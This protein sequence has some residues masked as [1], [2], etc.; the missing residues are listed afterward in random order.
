MRKVS[1]VLAGALLGATAMSL[2]H[3]PQVIS[4]AWS[5]GNADTY[6][7]LNLFGDV[8]E[9]VRAD[10]VEKPDDKQLVENAIQG[11]LSGLDPHSSYMDEKRYRDRKVDIRG[12]FGGLGIEVTMEN[13]LVKVMSPIDDT[14]AARAGILANDIITH[15]D[16]E[17][18][19]GLTLPQAVEKMRGA[20]NTPITLRILR[21]DSEPKD[22]KLVRDVIRIRIVKSRAEEDLGYVRIAQFTEQ[23]EDEMLKAIE[24]IKKKIPDDKL[25][26]WV[27]DLRNNPGGLLDQSIRVVD[28]FLDRGEVVS[29]RGRRP[30][31]IDRYSARPGDVTGGKPIIVLVNGGSASASEIVSGALQDHKRATIL[32]TRTFGKGSVQTILELG[33]NGQ[34][35]ALSLTTARYYTPC[36]RSIQATGITPDIVLEP[37][38]PDELKGKD[39]MQ[40]EAGLRGHLRGTNEPDP[41]EPKDGA[42]AADQAVAD[43]DDNGSSAYVPPDPKDDVQ[44]QLAYELIR[45]AKTDPKFPPKPGE[46]SSEC[47]QVAKAP[48]VKKSSAN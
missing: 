17:S 9:R 44:L 1:L 15:I 45:G 24:D 20:V 11:M 18:V 19:E 29:T 27:I 16:G 41:A 31:N 43:K 36:G 30:E 8:F 35:G 28:A 34:N 48:A 12:E 3:D 25:K 5:A 2:V 22:I 39:R 6:K 42:D 21:K 7:N 4:R 10:Y 37:V 23:T 33:P 14:P 26:G 38:I 47:A 46:L 13:N 32:G 40:G